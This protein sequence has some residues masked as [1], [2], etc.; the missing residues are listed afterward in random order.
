MSSCRLIVNAD[1]YGLSEKVNEG[2]IKAHR[3]GIVTSASLMANAEAF[4]SA[5]RLAKSNQSLD[6]GIHLTLTEEKPLSEPGK[7]PSLLGENNRFHCHATEFAKR[8]LTGK[9]SL[10]EV[11]LELDSQIRKVIDH[12]VMVSHLDSHQHV[13]ML[14]GIRKLVGKFAEK[15]SIKAIRYPKESLSPYMFVDTS[16]FNR[17]LQLL[18]LNTFCAINNTSDSRK[19]NRFYGFFYGG[20][21][22]KKRLWK[23]LESLQSNGTA[24]IMCHPGMCNHDNDYSHWGYM[25]QDEYNALTD[26][27]IKGY[28]ADKGIV[29]VGYRDV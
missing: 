22:T 27:E 6:V 21:L 3:D 12:G 29:L 4:E 13:H 9:I 23:I 24:E 2:I 18:V 1:D 26:E 19:T 11:A 15:Y 28:I 14:P 5:V 8:Y 10:D 17:L 25:W 7:I 20:K 16:G